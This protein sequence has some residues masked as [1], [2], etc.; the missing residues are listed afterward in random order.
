SR[1]AG[2]PAQ[3]GPAPM[4]PVASPLGTGRRPLLLVRRGLDHPASRRL[5]RPPLC[6]AVPSDPR[7][8]PA[9]RDGSASQPSITRATQR[10]A[11]AIRAWWTE[12]QPALPKRPQRTSAP[13]SGSLNLAAPYG[14]R[15]PALMPP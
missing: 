3:K 4:G 9:G 6:G 5:D 7:Q 1:P 14:R 12:H 15:T 11:V 8:S 10:E 13:L 2:T